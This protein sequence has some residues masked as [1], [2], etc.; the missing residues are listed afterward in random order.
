MIKYQEILG[1]PIFSVKEGRQWGRISGIMI[2]SKKF[3]ITGF[4]LEKIEKALPFEN[5]TTF[6][7]NSIVFPSGE[8]LQDISAAKKGK[9]MISAENIT[10]LRVITKKGR[11]IGRVHTFHFS[12]EEGVITHYEIEEGPFSD[13]K[14][15]SQDGV[16]L[17]GPH[18]IIITEEA[19]KIAQE[20][21]RK[22]ELGSFI[23][24]LAKKT[25]EISG[26]VAGRVKTYRDGT[27]KQMIEL[28]KATEKSV[29][30]LSEKAKEAGD[31]ARPEIEKLKKSA[32]TEAGKIAQKAK[33]INLKPKKK[34]AARKATMKPKARKKKQ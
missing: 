4:E 34:P 29:K 11:D 3:T 31:K 27:E 5:V 13:R 21:K 23:S 19:A 10:K 24:G 14:I 30:D 17:M 18:A 1:K 12:K 28:K 2:D 15:L 7:E 33:S 8:V 22:S 16:V 9:T 25:K 32:E 6:G 26:K 20:M